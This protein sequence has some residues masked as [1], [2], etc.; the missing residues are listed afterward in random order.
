MGEPLSNAA[1]REDSL[2]QSILVR[3]QGNVSAIRSHRA[4][5][6]TIK[7]TSDDNNFEAKNNIA[8]AAKCMLRYQYGSRIRAQA[9]CYAE[10]RDERKSDIFADTCSVY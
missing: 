9:E 7:E 8:D 4:S 3:G 1:R 6:A 10:E 5:I 2:R